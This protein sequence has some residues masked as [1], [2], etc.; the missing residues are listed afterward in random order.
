MYSLYAMIHFAYNRRR[1]DGTPLAWRH[2][3]FQAVRWH[4]VVAWRCITKWDTLSWFD[5][6]RSLW[7]FLSYRVIIPGQS[8]SFVTF[9]WSYQ[10]IV[11]A[12][13]RWCDHHQVTIVVSHHHRDH[14]Q[15][16]VVILC[17]WCYHTTSS[18]SFVSLIWSYAR[19]IVFVCVVGVNDNRLFD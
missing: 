1:S 17:R 2:S 8:L 4:A 3:Y 11:V 19:V 6:T 10:V 13:S 18:L 16:V 9:V 7:P 12:M 15:A 5:H 14:Y